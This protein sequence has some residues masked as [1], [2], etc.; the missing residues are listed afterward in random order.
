[1]AGDL[2]VIV[3]YVLKQRENNEPS[4]VTVGIIN[5][6]LDDLA[7]LKH[8]TIHHN[9]AWRDAGGG[10]AVPSQK[11]NLNE[12][13]EKWLIKVKDKGLSPLEHKWLVRII[14]RKPEFGLGWKFILP[15]YSKYAMD[16]YNAHNSL[17]NLCDRLADPQ[18][19]KDLEEQER[20]EKAARQGSA[21]RWEPQTQPATLGCII[22]PM[23]SA[24]VNFDNCLTS[25]TMNHVEYL[26]ATGNQKSQ[27][28]ALKFPAICGEIKLDG[29]RMLAHVF[30]GKVTI[31]TRNG[32]WYSELYS[33]VI[34]APLREALSMY[35]VNVILDGEMMSWDDKKQGIIPFGMNRTVANARR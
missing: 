4:K 10:S 2:S 21:S 20:V 12:A 6:L 29:E 18:F 23:L 8:R 28:L 7:G 3:E 30:N 5:K 25:I 17:K 22:S 32:N 31:Q 26:K 11:K 27:C 24:K 14:L 34:S 1:M 16:L 35:N 13:R 15:R 19:E 33:P 9:H